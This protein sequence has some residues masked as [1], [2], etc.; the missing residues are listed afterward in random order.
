MTWDIR[1]FGFHGLSVLVGRARP[2]ARC[3]DSSS[4]HLGGGCSVTAVREGRS[5]D[6]TMGYSPLEGVP[7]RRARGR[8]TPSRAA[9]AASAQARARGDRAHARVRVGPA[10]PLRLRQGVSRSSSA[11]EPEADLALRVFTH[12]IAAPSPRGGRRSTG[13]DALVFTGGIGSA[14]RASAARS[15]GGSAFLG[16]S[17]SMSSRRTRGRRR[18]PRGPR[19]SRLAVGQAPGTRCDQGRPRPAAPTTP[20][21]RAAASAGRRAAAGD[22]P[23]ALDPVGAR[24]QRVVAEHGVVDQP[25]VGLELVARQNESA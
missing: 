10:R 4:C 19:A 18:R 22:L 11:R 23:E 21:R 13:I 25:L 20:A 1:R 3:L 5:V 2:R 17:S 6:T 24:E 15:A 12:R 14:R 16:V 8:S 9:P 7:W